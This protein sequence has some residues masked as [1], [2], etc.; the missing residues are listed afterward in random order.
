M[1][2]LRTDQTLID[3]IHILNTGMLPKNLDQLKNEFYKLPKVIILPVRLHEFTTLPDILLKP[4]PMV[5]DMVLNV[6]RMYRIEPFTRSII[7]SEENSKHFKTYFLLYPD[8]DTVSLFQDFVLKRTSK[9]TMDCIISLDFAESIL[10]R[11][12]QGIELREYEEM[13]D[14]KR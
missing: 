7:L 3:R 10:N 11:G 9:D 14:V 6:M 5:S 13:E 8:E 4:Y 2:L 1:F 12:A